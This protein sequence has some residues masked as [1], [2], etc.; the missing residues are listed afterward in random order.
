M[1]TICPKHTRGVGNGFTLIELLVVIAIIAL[2]VSILLPAL[3][4]ARELAR[5]AYCMNNNK[6]MGVALHLYANDHNDSLMP[7]AA[8]YPV[9][10]FAF[11]YQGLGPYMGDTTAGL[12]GEQTPYLK[13]PTESF[14]FV[15]PYEQ[16]STSYGWNYLY[17]GWKNSA[18]PGERLSGWA[19]KL[20]GV[21]VP[22]E[23]I[24]I[25]DSKDGD[26]DIATRSRFI[27]IIGAVGSEYLLA[28]RHLGWGNYLMVAGNVTKLKPEE[29]TAN[30]CY[31]M[32]QDKSQTP[33]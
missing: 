11:W 8:S 32:K 28:Q 13:C 2:L 12:P 15:Y 20:S 21:P 5:G 14:Q 27:Y 1:N 19:S 7:G 10:V 4:G 9:T 6:Q 22:A 26:T 17:F 30:E 18:N 25:G 33:Y 24:I 3:T 23:T 16:F 31:Y 29:V